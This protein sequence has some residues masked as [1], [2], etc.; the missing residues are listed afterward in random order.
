MT[1]K[2]LH[3]L[4][5]IELGKKYRFRLMSDRVEVIGTVILVEPNPSNSSKG[6]IHTETANSRLYAGEYQYFQYD[7]DKDISSA[8]ENI[9]DLK[10]FAM[11]VFQLGR[12]DRSIFHKMG[13]DKVN[14][15]ISDWLKLNKDNY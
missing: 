14:K 7:E 9:E 8:F 12:E 10:L 5:I 1:Y 13:R 15:F 11:N 3:D 4:S 2:Y 6:K